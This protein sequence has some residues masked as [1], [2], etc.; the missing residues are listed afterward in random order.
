MGG[1]GFVG[2]GAITAAV[3]EGLG[4]GEIH[5]SPRGREVGRVLADR[6]PGVRVCAT[7]Q[8]VLDRADVVVLA[9][10]PPVAPDVLPG[11]EFRPDHVVVSAI[12]GLEIARLRDWTGPVAAIVR[13]IPLPGAARG[14]SLTALYPDHPVARDLFE[15][16]GGVVVPEEERT[17]DA[18]ST[19]TGTFAAYLEYL[20]TIT[21]WLADQGVAAGTASAYLRHI[22]GTLG[23]SLPAAESLTALSAEFTTPGGLNE[24]FATTLRAAG[25]PDTVRRTLDEL[26]AGLRDR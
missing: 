4:G 9:V 17:L 21:R 18:F 1:Y 16:V 23:E 7:N 19:V 8:E 6:F 14:R 13:S 2:T 11:L 12:A 5:L 26:L 15:R 24:R 10:R 22:H 25:V 3:V 20:T